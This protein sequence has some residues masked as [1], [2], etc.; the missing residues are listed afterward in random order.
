M[1]IP[2]LQPLYLS[3]KG[4]H[5]RVILLYTV[6]ILC[7]MKKVQVHHVVK[8]LTNT[9][10]VINIYCLAVWLCNRLKS[11]NTD[12]VV[13]TMLTFK[14]EEAPPPDCLKTMALLLIIDNVE[15]RRSA[16]MFTRLI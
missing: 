8:F 15:I 2:L 6:H 16:G 7:Y 11:G 9:V 14:K 10:Q 12:I 4:V 13:K 5:N 1:T 3:P